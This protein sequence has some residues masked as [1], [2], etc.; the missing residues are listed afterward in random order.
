MKKMSAK[1]ERREARDQLASMVDHLRAKTAELNQVAAHR[2][3]RVV[4][5]MTD[6]THE[7]RQKPP[8]A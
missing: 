6:L 8:D 5:D 7:G 2:L 1:A 3:E 4:K